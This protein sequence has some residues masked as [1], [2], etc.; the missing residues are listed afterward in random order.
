VSAQVGFPEQGGYAVISQ[1][2]RISVL[3]SLMVALLPE[4]VDAQGRVKSPIAVRKLE[5][6]ERIRTPEY[7]TTLSSGSKRP[8][9]WIRFS[10]LYDT[11]P[12]WMDG[13][14]FRYYVLLRN[15][16]APDGKLYTFCGLEVG[17]SDIEKGRNHISVA[18]LRPGAVERFGKVYAYAVEVVYKGQILA[19]RSEAEQKFIPKWWMDDRVMK[20]DKL[21]RRPGYLLNREQTPWALINVDD[22]EHIIK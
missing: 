16:K 22:F 18:F 14:T 6:V 8:K 15:P 21:V 10:V 5:K 17:Y 4:W 9:E 12:E 1:V 13:L 19:V 11:L 2:L 3:V 7:R 20:S